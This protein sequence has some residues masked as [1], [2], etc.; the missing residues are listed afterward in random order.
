MLEKVFLAH[1]FQFDIGSIKGHTRYE[2]LIAIDQ[3][4][5]IQEVQHSKLKI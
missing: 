5:R 4:I 1:N 2:L 3:P